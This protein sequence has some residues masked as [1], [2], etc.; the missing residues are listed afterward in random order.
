MGFREQVFSSGDDQN[1]IRVNG[2]DPADIAWGKK[3][4]FARFRKSRVVGWEWT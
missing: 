2:G 1:G 3:G 4:S